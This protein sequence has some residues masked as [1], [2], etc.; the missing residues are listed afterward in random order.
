MH[1]LGGRQVLVF[2]ILSN[3]PQF[4]KTLPAGLDRTGTRY[5]MALTFHLQR[6]F[7]DLG[8]RSSELQSDLLFTNNFPGDDQGV[9][10]LNV[11]LKTIR[12]E[13]VP[14]W[15]RPLVPL[16]QFPVSNS[17]RSGY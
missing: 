14:Y 16:A 5:S 12:T 3:V 17:D 4:L 13:D 11:I 8:K 10:V 9:S 15:V 1:H 2:E 6:G 7:E